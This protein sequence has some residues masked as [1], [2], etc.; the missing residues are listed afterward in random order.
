[1]S[2]LGLPT[3]IIY[4]IIEFLEEEDIL[5]LRATCWLLNE[6][7]QPFYYYKQMLYINY[8][9]F[10]GEL[11]NVF[12]SRSPPQKVW[13]G[14]DVVFQIESYDEEAMKKF[15]SSVES[16]HFEECKNL[17]D[18]I[19]FH[20][21]RY[22]ATLKTLT[23][24]GHYL[25][26]QTLFQNFPDN[27][28]D[29]V[30]AILANIEILEISGIIWSDE[31]IQ[32]ILSV[33][34]NIKELRLI[35]LFN[36]SAQHYYTIFNFSFASKLQALDFGYTKIELNTMKKLI[37]V[38]N[39]CL[40]KF[41]FSIK[42]SHEYLMME[43]LK[44]QH[45]SMEELVIYFSS[46]SSIEFLNFCGETLTGL[47][48][49]RLKNGFPKLHG[50]SF[51]KNLKFLEEL[52]LTDARDI[53]TESVFNPKYHV[54]YG[55]EGTY[56]YLKKLVFK[57]FA[58]RICCECWSKLTKSF[59]NLRHLNMYQIPLNEPSSSIILKNF[60]LK[61][62]NLDR[63]ELEDEH[64][65]DIKRQTNLKYLCIR[66]NEIKILPKLPNLRSLNASY[67]H[68]KS[69]DELIDNC[70]LL[71]RLDLSQC[72]FF[73]GYQT[74]RIGQ[75]LKKLKY[76]NISQC[77]QPVIWESFW[78][79][80]NYLQILIANGCDISIPTMKK[81]FDN[82]SSLTFFKFSTLGVKRFEYQTWIESNSNTINL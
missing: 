16:I 63:C 13:F 62:L 60:N 78:I 45:N 2:L 76:L 35:H 50:L 15:G 26:T 70:P 23:V 58:N 74:I 53:M 54:A 67:T 38:K 37:D 64:I 79:P 9:I 61:Y 31:Q 33:I 65:S 10:P 7:C 40:K 20:F 21:I 69:I 57:S 46:Y 19:F 49:F 25:A 77:I 6:I 18:E 73:E 17:N 80:C 59:F 41:F 11:L 55:I 12:K 66:R 3:E 22:F 43:F 29:T 52:E 75:K 82:I 51:M 81:M 71:E 39:L 5:E 28:D 4:N 56:P 27:L 32:R 42:E 30:V 24:T 68:I 36:T 72:L 8:Q 1:M 48:V 47:R 34:S 14:E 44:C